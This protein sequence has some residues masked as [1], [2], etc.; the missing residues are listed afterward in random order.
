MDDIMRWYQGN[1]D[2]LSEYAKIED[3]IYNWD[4]LGISYKF[5][6]LVGRDIPDSIKD[7][8]IHIG[9]DAKITEPD[10]MNML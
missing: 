1:R 2:K 10:P 6:D 9:I 7:K 5:I 4:I 8:G 3:F